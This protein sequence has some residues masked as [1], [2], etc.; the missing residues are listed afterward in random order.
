MN[1]G[2][3]K[4]CSLAIVGVVVFGAATGAL[5]LGGIFWT[6]LS[7]ERACQAALDDG[8][9]EALEGYLFMHPSGDCVVTVH[10]RLSQL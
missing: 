6:E 9:R 10:E 4:G 3:V 2:S 5:L 7:D 1:Q 8:S